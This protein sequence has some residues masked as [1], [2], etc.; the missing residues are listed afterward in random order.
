MT[1]DLMAYV[2]VKTEPPN[3][4]RRASEIAVNCML[5]GLLCFYICL[6]FAA[7]KV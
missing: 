5:I 7:F 1:T 4:L 6:A 3:R 2:T